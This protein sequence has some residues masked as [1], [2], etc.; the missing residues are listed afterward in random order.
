[1]LGNKWD[2]CS[3]SAAWAGWRADLQHLAVARSVLQA[4]PA[5]WSLASEL[6]WF[7]QALGCFQPQGLQCG[8]GL[9]CNV[10]TLSGDNK[11]ETCSVSAAWAGQCSVGAWSGWQGLQIATSCS[12]Q[13]CTATKTCSWNPVQIGVAGQPLASDLGWFD[14]CSWLLCF[15]PEGLECWTL[16]DLQCCN[17]AR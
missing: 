16:A 6:G 14:Q 4:R 7:D 12:G 11:L 10:A 15:Q 1:M 13:I 9:I 2:N 8:L 17:F 3:V 5:D